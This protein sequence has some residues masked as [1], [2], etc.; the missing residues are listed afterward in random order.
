[1]SKRLQSGKWQMVSNTVTISDSSGNSGITF[2]N[3]KPSVK[4]FTDLIN[5]TTLAGNS[6]TIGNGTSNTGILLSNEAIGDASFGINVGTPTQGGFYNNSISLGSG[7]TDDITLNNN[8]TNGTIGINVN[9]FGQ[10]LS[11]ANFDATVTQTGS[12]TGGI[13]ITP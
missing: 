12:N 4:I 7:S 2:V 10:G 1:M 3:N 13:T 8:A 11:P 9:S 6:I 5:I